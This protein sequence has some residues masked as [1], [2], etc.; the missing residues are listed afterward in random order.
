MLHPTLYRRGAASI[1]DDFFNVRRDF[2]RLLDD[3]GRSE[4]TSAWVP[5][6]NVRETSDAIEV[7]AELPG[8]DPDDVDV[9]VENGVL[10]ISGER[11]AEVEE[12]KKGS[13]YHLI[14]RR[15]GRFE[16]TFTLPRSVNA[17]S[18]DARFVNGVLHITLPKVEAAKPRRIPIKSGNGATIGKK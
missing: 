3:F 4:V 2:D 15:Y 5:A 13:E 18:V 6:V 1:W 8:L 12:G 7:K 16:R 17:E 14:E 11:K 9:R 10:S